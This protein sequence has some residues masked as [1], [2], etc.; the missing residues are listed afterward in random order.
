[1]SLCDTPPP[2]PHHHHHFCLRQSIHLFVYPSPSVPLPLPPPLPPHT[3]TWSHTCAIIRVL[4]AHTGRRVLRTHKKIPTLKFLL[5]LST[6][7][8]KTHITKSLQTHSGR[9]GAALLNSAPAVSTSDGHGQGP[10]S[11]QSSSLSPP[12]TVMAKGLGRGK[13]LP[14]L[15]L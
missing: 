13:A 10:R 6:L 15:H 4:C 14:C 9:G 2:S 8:T 1:M 11:W 5:T 3:H 12:L 7:T